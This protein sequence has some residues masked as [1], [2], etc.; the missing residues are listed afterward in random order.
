MLIDAGEWTITPVTN[1]GILP[2]QTLTAESTQV[3]FINYVLYPSPILIQCNISGTARAGRKGTVVDSKGLTYTTYSND[4]GV[5]LFQINNTGNF[6]FEIYGGSNTTGYRNTG[7][8]VAGEKFMFATELNWTSTQILITT[9]Q[10]F[11]SPMTGKLGVRLFGAGGF[12]R[13]GGGHMSYQI[14]DFK[15]GEIYNVIIGQPSPNNGGSTSFGNVLTAIGGS[16]ATN[17]H[18]GGTGGS[19]GGNGSYGGGGGGDRYGGNGK[20]GS[21][22]GGKFTATGG[23]GAS[24]SNNNYQ[25]YGEN[26]ITTSNLEFNGSGKGGTSSTTYGRGNGGN[27]GIYGGGGGCG[28]GRAADASGGPGYTGYGGGGGGGYGGNGGNGQ[29]GEC[30]GG[31]GG[32]GGDG[33]A[34]GGG[35]GYGGD[36]SYGGGGYGMTNLI[37]GAYGYGAGGNPDKEGAPG[38]CI[39]YFPTSP[40]INQGLFP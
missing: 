19:K 4:D 14:L 39:I 30:G 7:V 25:E 18:H 29:Y 10:E 3:K 33:S 40:Y 38:I 22:G 13:G 21:G 28:S 9:S 36:G 27:G 6:T 23:G 31:G 32:Y 15:I 8:A 11:V 16:S 1:A 20:G 17:G 2:I 24:V 26:G 35:G 34:Y 12:D 5:M 37:N